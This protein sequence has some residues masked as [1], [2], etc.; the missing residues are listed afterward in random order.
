MVY[1]ASNLDGALSFLRSATSDHMDLIILDAALCNTRADAIEAVRREGGPARVVV[2]GHDI[3][4]IDD[5]LL[6]ADGVLTFDITADTMIR[7]LSLVKNGERVVPRELMQA[8]A[9]RSQSAREQSPSPPPS[10]PAPPPEPGPGRNPAPS[11][12]EVEIL[13]RLLQGVPNRTIARELGITET[14]IKVHLKSLWRKIGVSNRTQA[15]V[16]ALNNGY[17]ADG[18]APGSAG[19]GNVTQPAGDDGDGRN[20]GLLTGSRR[21][22]SD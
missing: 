20:E 3:S 22:K 7:S 19:A 1:E 8:I 2:I 12:R 17:R 13:Q 16:W 14:T 4:A 10:P 6:A 11:P 5:R 15:A 18:V 21:G 9:A